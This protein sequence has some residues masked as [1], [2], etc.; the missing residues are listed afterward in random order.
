[1]TRYLAMCSGNPRR[2]MLQWGYPAT[3]ASPRI[4]TKAE[5]ARRI[6][7]HVGVELYDDSGMAP[8]TVAIYSLSDP[9][10]L[11]HPRYIGQT[12]RPSE[13][14]S[15]HLNTA[16]LWLP[17]D[18]PWWVKSPRLR[19]LYGWIRALYREDL[20]LPTMLI[21]AWLDSVSE[22]RLAERARIYECLAER[23]TLLNV[24]TEILGRQIPLV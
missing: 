8:K 9:R 4:L 17:D 24:E 20:R 22:A 14:F 7:G 11:R 12:T 1:M 15:Q 21:S 3:A 19:P 13:R 10:D 6:R 18:L 5:L 2:G 16:R 23:M